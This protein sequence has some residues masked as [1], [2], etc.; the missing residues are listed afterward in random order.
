MIKIICTTI[1]TLSILLLLTWQHFHGGVPSHHILQQKDLPE[2]S[3]WWGA[4]FLPIISWLLIRK[5]LLE[6]QCYLF[7]DLFSEL[8]QLSHLLI[9]TNYFQIMFR[10]H[11]YYQ[12]CSF[13]SS[14]QNSFWGLFLVWFIISVLFYHQFLFSYLRY[15]GFLFIDILDH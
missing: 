15:R 6:F 11:Y 5:T 14:I 10:I 8:L 9:I 1:I 13:Q 2:I 12:A 7:L 3:N 4:L